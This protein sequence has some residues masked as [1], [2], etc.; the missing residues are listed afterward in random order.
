MVPL[1]VLLV[2][3]NCEALLPYIEGPSQ[4]IVTTRNHM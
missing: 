1:A 2:W 3:M 4:L